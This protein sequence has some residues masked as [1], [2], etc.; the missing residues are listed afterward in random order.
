LRLLDGNAE[1]VPGVR[2]FVT[3]GH[4]E[5]H[6]VVVIESQ[7]QTAVYLADLCPS[8]RHFPSRWGMSYDVDMLETRRQ[9]PEW[10]GRIADHNW[11]ALFD[12][13]PDHAAAYLE[14]DGRGGIRIRE[15]FAKL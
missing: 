12:H 10:L 4:T 15:A 13:D 1:I 9:K 7:G 3:G 11:L 14:R 6:A 2:F 5:G 8:T